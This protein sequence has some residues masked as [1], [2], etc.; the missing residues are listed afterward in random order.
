MTK[1]TTVLGSRQLYYYDFNN[2]V[3]GQIRVEDL[4]ANFDSKYMDRDCVIIFNEEEDLEWL[5]REIKNWATDDEHE[6]S[7]LKIHYEIVYGFEK[8][9]SDVGDYTELNPEKQRT[10]EGL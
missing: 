7:W 3:H 9:F 6:P 10:K 5:V 1:K 8:G 2:N 4:K